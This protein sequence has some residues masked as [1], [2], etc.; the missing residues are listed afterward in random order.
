MAFDELQAHHRQLEQEYL[1]RIEGQTKE[2]LNPPQVTLP[3][4]KPALEVPTTTRKLPVNQSIVATPVE[5]EK[6]T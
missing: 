1:A 6:Q 4:N 5:V 3:L 2:E